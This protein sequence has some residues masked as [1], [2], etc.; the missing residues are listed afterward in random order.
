VLIS[1]VINTNQYRY[2][3]V[4]LSL[5]LTKHYAMNTYGGVYVQTHIFLTSALVRGEW[6]ASI[7]H[8]RIKVR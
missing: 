3:N 8:T 2:G 1:N 7:P 5:C 4:K 6:S